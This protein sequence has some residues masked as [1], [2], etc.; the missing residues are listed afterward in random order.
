MGFIQ[1]LLHY[2]H[3]YQEKLRFKSLFGYYA[4]E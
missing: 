3:P 2:Q 1:V 4:I